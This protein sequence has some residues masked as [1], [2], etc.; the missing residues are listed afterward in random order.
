LHHNERTILENAL[1]KCE[2]IRNSER[3][4]EERLAVF[5]TYIKNVIEYQP[6]KR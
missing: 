3:I 4:A 2:R 5:C 6:L 1:E